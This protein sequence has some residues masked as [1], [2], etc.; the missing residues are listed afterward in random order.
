[1]NYEKDEDAKV[2]VK[3]TVQHWVAGV[4]QLDDDVEVDVYKR[5]SER[6]CA[7]STYGKFP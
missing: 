5:Q 4:H 3:Y 2:E 7:Q 1:M 6:C